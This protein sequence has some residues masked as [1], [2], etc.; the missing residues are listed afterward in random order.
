MAIGEVKIPTS[1]RV[2]WMFEG[3]MGDVEVVGTS[4]KDKTYPKRPS[5]RGSCEVVAGRI[6]AASCKKEVGVGI[7]VLG[8]V[9]AAVR[10]G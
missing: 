6:V 9:V 1:E 7:G 3:I 5:R 2:E 4:I 8:R 10:P